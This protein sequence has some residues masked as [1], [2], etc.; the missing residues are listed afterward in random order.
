MV[1]RPILYTAQK[2]GLNGGKKHH[3]GCV[4]GHGLGKRMIHII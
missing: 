1:A 4:Y 3:A 2:S